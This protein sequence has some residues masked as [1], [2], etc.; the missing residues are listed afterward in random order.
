MDEMTKLSYLQW[1]DVYTAEKPYQVFL[2]L[3]EGV[4]EEK[5]SNLEFD[6][7]DTEL[8]RDLRAADT[9]FSLDEHGFTTAT[10]ELCPHSFSEDEINNQYIPEVCEM[11]KKSTNADRVISFDWRI[12]KSVSPVKADVI[13]KNDNM[14]PLLPALHVHI[15]WAPP[16]RE[17]SHH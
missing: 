5:L 7:G 3:P 6:L 11:V 4:P 13:D 15:G 14:M 8:I 1:Q 16:T 9:L 17:A 12:S 10:M 2:A